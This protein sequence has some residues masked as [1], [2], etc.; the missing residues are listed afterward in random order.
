MFLF[1]TL[2]FQLGDLRDAVDKGSAW[3]AGAGSAKPTQKKR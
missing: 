1:L 3:K 2:L